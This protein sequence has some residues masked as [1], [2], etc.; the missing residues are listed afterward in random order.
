MKQILFICMLVIIFSLSFTVQAKDEK[1]LDEHWNGFITTTELEYL[2][3]EGEIELELSSATYD[4]DYKMVI[5]GFTGGYVFE[6]IELIGDFTG[7]SSFDGEFAYLDSGI[8]FKGSVKARLF[9]QD[10]FQFAV[11]ASAD[12]RINLWKEGVTYDLDFYSEKALGDNL[13]LHNNFLCEFVDTTLVKRLYNGL[14]Y[15]YNQHHALKAYLYTG[16][17][18]FDSLT[19]SLN[20]MYRNDFYDQ[21]TF[22]SY[23]KIDEDNLLFGNEVEIIPISDL[24]VTGYYKFMTEKKDLVG[25]DLRK[26]FTNCQLNGSYQYSED[27]SLLSGGIAYELSR[28][29]EVRLQFDRYVEKDD[30]NYN[31]YL[32]VR[33]V[34]T[35]SI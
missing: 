7:V 24:I 27:Q 5:Y 34:V 15:R 18:E 26:D 3:E 30:V 11:K 22:L 12:R 31:D 21:A 1:I 17:I 9:D 28:D 14:S 8:K 32:E 19:N 33:S 23:F 35:Y 4:D 2:P 6:G 29:M 16:F 13:V 10:G 25:I 20:L